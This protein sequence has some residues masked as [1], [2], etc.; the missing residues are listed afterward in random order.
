M[1]AGNQWASHYG[2]GWIADMQKVW[3][4]GY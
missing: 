2:N 4:L 3:M 1:T